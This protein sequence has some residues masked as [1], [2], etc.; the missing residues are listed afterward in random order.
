MMRMR[1]ITLCQLAPNICSVYTMTHSENSGLSANNHHLPIF[2]LPLGFHT[3]Q[4]W[5]HCMALE[6][7]RHKM[8]LYQGTRDRVIT[9]YNYGSFMYTISATQM[10]MSQHDDGIAGKHLDTFALCQK[11]D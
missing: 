8:K 11:Y 10:A 6:A 4:L 9:D 1:F 2:D 7:E 3:P 5:F